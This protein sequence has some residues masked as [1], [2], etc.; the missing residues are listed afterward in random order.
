V[1][2]IKKWLESDTPDYHSGVRLFAQHSKNRSL[3]HYLTRKGDKAMSKLRYELEKIAHIRTP[4]IGRRAPRIAT[5]ANKVKPATTA[6]VP[7]VTL[8]PS[9]VLAVR[10]TIDPEGKINPKDLP[11]HLR[12]LYEKNVEDY[13]LLRGAH[14]DMKVAKT[15]NE[16]KKYRKLIAKLDDA[17]AAHW[18]LIDQ[19]VAT[20]TAPAPAT[21]TATGTANSPLSPQEVNTFR[22]YLSRGLA[23]PDKIT[24]GKRDT[25][26]E[27]LSAL[28][29]DGQK[30]DD[31]TVVKLTELGFKM[32]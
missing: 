10:I 1:E 3:L 28:L 24:A 19:W 30:F 21:G 12:I 11:E 16:R 5:V 7:V 14:A 20:G 32:E 23:E 6:P 15:K 31:D 18:A 25:M 27:R 4:A 8:P 26:Q 17:I 22:T 29:A 9:P 2:N 13:K